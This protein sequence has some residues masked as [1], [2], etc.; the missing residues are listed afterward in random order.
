MADETHDETSVQRRLATFAQTDAAAAQVEY[1]D[2]GRQIYTCLAYGYEQT[3]RHGTTLARG[4][5]AE[6]KPDDFRI[7]WAHDQRGLPVGKP[8]SITE[9]D[10][11]PVVK[12]VFADTEQAQELRR[13]VDGGFLRGVSIGFI[14]DPKAVHVRSD[15]VTVYSRV[16][17]LELSLVNCP[18]SES[19]LIQLSRSLD[20]D[21]AELREL[22]PEL[23]VEEPALE[24]RGNAE[25]NEEISEAAN[26]TTFAPPVDELARA[27]E[28]LRAAGVSEDVLAQLVPVPAAECDTAERD[29]E[30]ARKQRM[31]HNLFLLRNARL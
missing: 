17:L 14:P 27:V 4:A 8:V 22:F 3:D 18:S 16:S 13:L 15:G 31:L 30:A 26:A 20:S 1:D 12:W 7:L 24:E 25:L 21:P 28:T 10:A 5:M 19:A 2:E 11:G 6:V 29:A 9:T 23:A